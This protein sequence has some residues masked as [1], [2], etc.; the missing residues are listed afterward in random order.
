LNNLCWRQPSLQEARIGQATVQLLGSPFTWRVHQ[1]TTDDTTMH[2]AVWVGGSKGSGACEWY[3]CMARSDNKQRRQQVRRPGNS[4]ECCAVCLEIR[5]GS[6][7]GSEGMQVVG[8]AAH[9]RAH[10]SVQVMGGWRCPARAAG[11]HSS[12]RRPLNSSAITVCT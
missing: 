9:D 4:R 3:C 11:P 6:R 10:L 1:A 7:A 12:M 8:G 2:I 5:T